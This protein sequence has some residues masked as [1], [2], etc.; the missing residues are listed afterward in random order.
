MTPWYHL[1]FLRVLHLSLAASRQLPSWHSPPQSHCFP[2]VTHLFFLHLMLTSLVLLGRC[3]L[4][5]SLHCHSRERTSLEKPPIPLFPLCRLGKGALP[6]AALGCRSQGL[7]AWGL[8]LLSFILLSGF[9]FPTCTSGCLKS[10]WRPKYQEAESPLAPDPRHWSR[11]IKLID[12]HMDE[13][14]C[15]HTCKHIHV[16]TMQS[17]SHTVHN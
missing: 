9:P 13:H 11:P 12:T 4:S 15:T 1:L 2:H 14:V 17:H 8:L 3:L 10:E 5:H 6:P 16:H 7:T